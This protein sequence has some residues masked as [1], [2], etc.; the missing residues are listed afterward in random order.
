MNPRPPAT[1]GIPGTPGAP[2]KLTD[3]AYD[4][5]LDAHADRSLTPL[6]RRA[7]EAELAADPDRRQRFEREEQLAAWLRTPAAAPDQ[8]DA[9]LDA[10]E[11]SRA[12]AVLEA[13]QDALRLARRRSRWVDGVVMAAAAGLGLAVAAWA[14]TWSRPGWIG[15]AG[16]G[17]PV[18]APA[19]PVVAAPAAAGGPAPAAALGLR[20][21]SGDPATHWDTRIDRPAAGEP[22][23]V[24]HLPPLPPRGV[25]RKVDPAST[26]PPAKPAPAGAEPK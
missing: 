15:P 2:A 20:P 5:L 7:L 4:A 23:S 26:K 6:A 14:V 18:A 25:A 10:W 16:S 9:I 12:T 13:H 21:G 19:G 22:A 11:S 8:T 3:A 24:E 17:G 1:P